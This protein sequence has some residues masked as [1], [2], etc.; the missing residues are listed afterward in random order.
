MLSLQ[1]L[2]KSAIEQS[3]SQPE[4]EQKRP[5]TPSAPTGLGIGHRNH[6]GKVDFSSIQAFPTTGMIP[7]S[8]NLQA[9]GVNTPSVNGGSTGTG[10]CLGLRGS[11]HG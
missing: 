9:A 11:D 6:P 1:A 3:R 7:P 2:T 5:F 8:P 10:K 4:S